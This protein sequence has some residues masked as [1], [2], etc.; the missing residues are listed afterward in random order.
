MFVPSISLP[1]ISIANSKKTMREILNGSSFNG[2]ITGVLFDLNQNRILDSHNKDLK[3]PIASVTKAVTAVY[4]IETIGKEHYFET[5]LLTDGAVTDGILEGN[6]YLI[7]GADPSLSNSD[8]NKL[9]I[10]LRANG[11]KE[12]R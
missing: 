10:S 1:L 4:G 9:T 7:G 11:I 12:I 3:L 6:L 2:Q 8:L 5:N